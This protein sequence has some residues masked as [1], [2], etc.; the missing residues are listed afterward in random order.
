MNRICSICTHNVFFLPCRSPGRGI[1]VD[2]E[3][4]DC[5]MRRQGSIESIKPVLPSQLFVEFV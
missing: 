5:C 2:V 4:D 1:E 3:V